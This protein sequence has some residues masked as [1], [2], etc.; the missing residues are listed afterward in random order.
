[1]LVDLGSRPGVACFA[2][3]GGVGHYEAQ[4]I[5]VLE[6]GQDGIRRV[7][8]FLD[9]RLFASLSLPHRLGAEHPAFST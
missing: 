3:R 2:R 1:M 7:T 4:A 9:P 6:L 5:D 8:S